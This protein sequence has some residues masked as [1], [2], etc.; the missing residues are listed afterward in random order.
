VKTVF[1]AVED[2]IQRQ[3]NGTVD[4]VTCLSNDVSIL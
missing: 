2:L 4:R 1:G 3:D